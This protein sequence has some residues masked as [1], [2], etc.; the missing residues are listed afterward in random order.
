MVHW[1]GPVERGR[2]VGSRD[3]GSWGRDVRSRGVGSRSVGRLRVS[4]VNG[5]PGVHHIGDVAAVGVVHLVVDG[6]EAAVGKGD[7]VGAGGGV[8]VALLAGVDLDAVVVVHGVVVGVDSRLVVGGGCCVGRSRGIAVARG[9]V[10]GGQSGDSKNN[11]SLNIKICV[12]NT[13]RPG[14]R[15]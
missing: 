5:L 7:R 12:Q 11:E 8:A 13:V 9:V 6:L 2:L 15:S 10:G 1:S 14:F 4:G 3:V